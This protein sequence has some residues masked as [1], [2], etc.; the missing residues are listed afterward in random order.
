MTKFYVARTGNMYVRDYHRLTLSRKITDIELTD[1]FKEAKIFTDF[2]YSYV[3]KK[4][5][6]KFYKIDE[7]EVSEESEHY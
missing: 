1:N 7:K 4:S 5:D 6:I 3:F 2:L